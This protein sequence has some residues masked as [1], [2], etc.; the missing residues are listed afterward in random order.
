MSDSLIDEAV[1]CCRNVIAE[2][3]D[4]PIR[5]ALTLRLGLLEGAAWSI[6]LEPAAEAEVVRL[7]RMLLELRDDVVRA[8]QTLRATVSSVG[9]AGRA[10][11]F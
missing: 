9:L 4:G 11:A 10:R 5:R 3:D 7:V 6:A 2:L 1:A 8:R